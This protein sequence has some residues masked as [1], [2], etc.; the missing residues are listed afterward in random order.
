MDIIKPE[1]NGNSI[2]NIYASVIKFFGGNSDRIPLKYNL[3]RKDKFVLIILDAFGLSVFDKIKTP[4]ADAEV[5]RITSIFPS[6][7]AAAM[8]SFYTGLT[9]SEHGVMGFTTYMKEFGS[10]INMLNLS[11][12]SQEEPIQMLAQNFSRYISEKAIPLGVELS[13]LGVSSTAILPNSISDSPT[14]I[15]HTRGMNRVKYY[16]PWDALIQMKKLLSNEGKTFISVYI[17]VVDTLSHHYGPQSQ[18]TLSS[19]EDLLAMISKSL[20]GIKGF[21]ALI[22]A[23]HGQVPNDKT[24]V[25]NQQL[26]DILEMPPFGDSRAVFLNV[27]NEDSAI[28]YFEKNLGGFVLFRKS[29]V[30]KNE[31]LGPRLNPRFESRVGDILAVPQVNESLIYSYRG[32]GDADYIAFKGHHGGLMQEEQGVPLMIIQR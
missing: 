13:K 20:S 21:T 14:T 1:Y 8:L 32:E 27:K 7:T 22:T 26:M 28:R 10:I 9:P 12:P 3:G 15:F 24:N 29:E 31:Y 18:E 30:I 19:A 11:H 6:T 23:D 5:K 25:V 17:P 4:L 16:Y 2:A